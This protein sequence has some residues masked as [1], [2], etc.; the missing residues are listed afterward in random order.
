MRNSN[1]YDGRRP[2]T[3]VNEDM[4]YPTSSHPHHASGSYAGQQAQHHQQR[5]GVANDGF[6]Q[7][8]TQ[9]GQP[10]FR[11]DAEP[12]E[13]G[14]RRKQRQESNPSPPASIYGNIH[15]FSHSGSL[16]G[17]GDLQEQAR[18]PSRS[19]DNYAMPN[20]NSN[21][22]RGPR[23]QDQYSTAP[24]HYPP[25][26]A[27]QGYTNRSSP[28][29]LPDDHD[30]SGESRG[31]SQTTRA[32]PNFT[33]YHNQ[34]PRQAVPPF[35][36]SGTVVLGGNTPIHITH[37][38]HDVMKEYES[39]HGV[40]RSVHGRSSARSVFRNKSSYRE[41]CVVSGSEVKVKSSA[42]NRGAGAAPPPSY[43][44]SKL[45]GNR[46][47]QEQQYRESDKNSRNAPSPSLG[48]VG[49][50]SCLLT[51]ARQQVIHDEDLIGMATPSILDLP[52]DSPQRILLSLRTPS[53]SASHS[54]D[55]RDG[56]VTTKAETSEGKGSDDDEGGTNTAELL[57]LSPPEN[58]RLTQHRS[59]K[60]GFT[61]GFFAGKKSSYSERGGSTAVNKTHAA[62][63]SGDKSPM[64]SSFSMSALPSPPHYTNSNGEQIEIANSFSF[65]NPSSF[66]SLGECTQ[67][68]KR[69]NGDNIISLS[70]FGSEVVESHQIGKREE[71]YHGEGRAPQNHGDCATTTATTPT[72]SIGVD[73]SMGIGTMQTVGM[74]RSSDSMSLLDFGPM[75]SRTGSFGER[76]GSLRANN[77]IDGFSDGV[78]SPPQVFH[79]YSS[80]Q[81]YHNISSTTKSQPLPY[82]QTSA[83][84]P[85]SSNNID[86]R[87][88]N[89]D[90]L[91]RALI[92]NDNRSNSY[93]S[94]Y[95]SGTSGSGP[96]I[97]Y[98]DICIAPGE[99][100]IPGF[101]YSLIRMRDAFEEFSFLLPGLKMALKRGRSK[102]V[103]DVV[104]S[105]D[106]DPS[107]PGLQK[108]PSLS[109]SD[110]VVA[111]R[112]VI[113]A[114]CAFGG[115]RC[116]SK[117][118]QS[119]RGSIFRNVGSDEKNDIV[120][121][122][123]YEYDEYFSKRYYE[124][125]NR[126]SWAFEET[127]PVISS[128]EASFL[129]EQQKQHQLN[130]GESNSPRKPGLLIADHDDRNDRS[131]SDLKSSPSSPTKR[132]SA[133][134]PSKNNGQP[135]MRYRCKLCGQPKQN[136][137][138][139]YQQSLQ[140][141][142]G[143]SVYPA[144][145]AFT[146]DEPGRLAPSL[147]EMNNFVCDNTDGSPD[148]PSVNAN[149]L[150]SP[151]SIRPK[152]VAAPTSNNSPSTFYS[153]P[154]RSKTGVLVK[155]NMSTPFGT[156]N[157]DAQ[158]PFPAQNGMEHHN[159]A[160]ASK[161]I[162]RKRHIGQV[163]ASSSEEEVLFMKPMELR[164]EQF[165]TVTPRTVPSRS[166]TSEQGSYCY[167]QLPLPYKQRK[168][169]SDNLF[170]LS[171]EVQHLT[172]ECAVVLKEA[173]EKDM[174]DLAVSEL[175]TQ[176]IVVLHCPVNDGGFEGL[177]NYL[178]TLGIAC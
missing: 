131:D 166:S 28:T 158:A 171:K 147:T 58:Q 117:L 107:A 41:T 42:M 84:L 157:N 176:V 96:N 53:M 66:D 1:R 92:N 93:G 138:C 73:I 85:S 121:G 135:K 51:P 119:D 60:A 95:S 9:Q 136:H 36:K 124:N 94:H 146:A 14:M 80:Q 167:P 54:F 30:K 57:V 48:G 163:S 99:A 46:F 103:V 154:F 90:K 23:P 122:R 7:C 174:W 74:T 125:E 11:G 12:R 123:P 91:N 69:D 56:S 13:N 101:Y 26:H 139:P 148:R 39:S 76:R 49:E 19:Y 109:E 6:M 37:N 111:K 72:F 86:K 162:S 18:F 17:S 47:P 110:M 113:A 38:S 82:S 177:K 83:T 130:G 150:V 173:R 33:I 52:E 71:L 133:N 64:N 29:I 160:S 141:S 112:R 62:S 31:H 34:T 116:K 44:N 32:S 59:N 126:I 27:H 156:V 168:S 2:A 15:T 77:S 159:H 118:K 128:E 22:G 164:P 115:S 16:R 70:Q 50:L 21:N 81:H 4:M 165:R 144:V 134:S 45:T 143:I 108:L 63:P 78:E 175:M 68:Q 55:W 87:A 24:S 40:G 8:Y 25:H 75:A 127:P 178:L 89:D 3:S 35:S 43:G 161:T 120:T 102:L 106:A 79:Q 97:F 98:P 10:P 100:S 170:S 155:T 140:R 152:S 151:N 145:N 172:D 129:R 153:T 65:F 104:L 20:N 169:L 105:P 61:D 137:V 132:D 88:H 67:L 114:V 149:N 5:A 142:I